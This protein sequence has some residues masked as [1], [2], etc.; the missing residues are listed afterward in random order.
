MFTF[1]LD[2]GHGFNTAGKRCLKSIDKNETREWYLNQRI[3]TKLEL[4]LADYKDVK[5]IRVDDPTGAVDVPLKKRTDIA[6]AL[7]TTLYLS[8]HHDAG[9]N[10]STAGGISVFTYDDRAEL[11]N[12]RSTLYDSLRQAGGL[13]GRANP[14]RS[15]DFHVLRETRANAVLVECGFMDS[16]TDTPIILTDEYAEKIACGFM[17][18]LESYYKLERKANT[19][20]TPTPAPTEAGKL[21]RVQVGAFKSRENA[22]KFL[23]QV[24]A[25]G[26]H[27]AF[28]TL[29][30]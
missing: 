30:N 25:S 14:K 15:A 13:G 1:V 29:A 6:N 28:I 17:N 4:K 26:Y 7:D 21:Y 22:E 2:A 9:A 24:K 20:A 3:A 16:A 23:Q 12:I 10:G 19:P 11:A 5:V 18:F 8:I 27:E